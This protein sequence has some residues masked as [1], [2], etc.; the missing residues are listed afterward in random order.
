M[1]ILLVLLVLLL[2]FGGGG[3][4]FGGPAIGGGGLGLVLVICLIIWVMGGFRTTKNWPAIPVRGVLADATSC[5]RF[6]CP[7]GESRSDVW[8]LPGISMPG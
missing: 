1:N 2:L 4:Y 5:E 8:Q 3:F 7:V 6:A